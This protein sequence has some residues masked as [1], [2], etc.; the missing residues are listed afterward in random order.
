MLNKSNLSGACKVSAI[1]IVNY[2]RICHVVGKVS[3]DPEF[4]LLGLAWDFTEE[5]GFR[6]F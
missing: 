3:Q 5:G 1:S 2:R 6:P 4:E